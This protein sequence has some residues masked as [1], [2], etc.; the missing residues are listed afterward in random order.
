[1][2]LYI[3]EVGQLVVP[4][5]G[6]F[7]LFDFF[8]ADPD[9]VLDHNVIVGPIVAT[10]VELGG[11]VGRVKVGDVLGEVDVLVCHPELQSCG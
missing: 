1:M 10:V 6:P 8:G 9:L 2:L 7:H 3:S 5:I 4:A 11:D